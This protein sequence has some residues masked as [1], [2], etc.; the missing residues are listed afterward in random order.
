[1][2]RIE[3][4]DLVLPFPSLRQRIVTKPELQGQ[5]GSHVPFVHRIDR[6]G[7]VDVVTDR[8]AILLLVVLGQAEQ[9]VDDAVTN[10]AISGAG[11]T[12]QRASDWL[13]EN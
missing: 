9:P 1:M 7:L 6:R 5:A 11:L 8:L 10:H 2:V 12:W 3:V 13:P 4:A